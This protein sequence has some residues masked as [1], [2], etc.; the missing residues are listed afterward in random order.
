[1]SDYRVEGWTEKIC[2][3]CG[4]YESDSPIYRKYPKLFE[5]MV[6]ENPTYFLKKFLK[7]RPSDEYLQQHKSDE[8]FTEPVNA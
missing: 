3:Y 1:M 6:R 8:E 7:L 2:W 5:N 4:H